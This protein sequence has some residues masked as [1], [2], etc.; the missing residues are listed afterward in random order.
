MPVTR[1]A[2]QTPSR[3][4]GLQSHEMG[5]R[6]AAPSARPGAPSAAESASWIARPF[7]SKNR[8]NSSFLNSMSSVLSVGNRRKK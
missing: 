8:R 3:L 7:F 2:S 5:R 6:I 4:S 1:H